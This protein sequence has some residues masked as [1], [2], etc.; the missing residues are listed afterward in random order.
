MVKV[1]QVW[2]YER[3]FMCVG[4]K[5]NKS[6]SCYGLSGKSAL[7]TLTF[8]VIGLE[9]VADIQRGR[10]EQHVWLQGLVAPHAER[11]LAE[12]SHD[13]A[14]SKQMGYNLRFYGFLHLGSVSSITVSR[15]VTLYRAPFSPFN[16][17]C[18][19]NYRLQSK[20]KHILVSHLKPPDLCGRHYINQSSCYGYGQEEG[21]QVF[22]TIT[23]RAI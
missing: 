22:I 12:G 20:N 1:E 17:C 3:C 14:E 21:Q 23:M 11:Q 10:A 8:H 7:F 2:S 18:F 13:P 5:K 19:R 15:L 9:R 6:I 16:F 4:T